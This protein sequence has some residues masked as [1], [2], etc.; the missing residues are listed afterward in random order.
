MKD[1]PSIKKGIYVHY[2]SDHMRYEVFGVG[3]NSETDEFYVVYKPLYKQDGPQPDFWV[4]P[5]D[6]F[7]ED[8]EIDGV[9]RPRFTFV[10]DK[11]H[12]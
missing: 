3:R 10:S 5:Y 8:V 1:V 4:R 12:L 7:I 9:K 6:M 2:K 11:A